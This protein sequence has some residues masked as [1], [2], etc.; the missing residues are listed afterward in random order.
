[1]LTCYASGAR[2]SLTEC[3]IYD[4]I[5]VKGLSS[6]I[7]GLNNPALQQLIKQADV[8][9]FQGQLA[10]LLLLDDLHDLIVDGG[11]TPSL[12]P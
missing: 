3:T 2:Y 12:R 9:G 7:Q 6:E 4:T 1:M 5:F 10:G 11:G 8:A